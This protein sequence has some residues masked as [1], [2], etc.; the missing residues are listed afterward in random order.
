MRRIEIEMPPSRLRVGRAAVPSWLG[1]GV[2]PR[3]LPIQVA[4]LNQTLLLAVPFE[5]NV[6][7]GLAWKAE[8]AKRGYDLILVGYANEYAGYV[9]PEATY[10]TEKYE[11]RTSFYGAQLVNYLT[12]VV[13]KLMESFEK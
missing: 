5:L 13:V 8:A 4:R 3:R 1:D 10:A 11:A 7:I 6:E 12:E 2:F 9:V